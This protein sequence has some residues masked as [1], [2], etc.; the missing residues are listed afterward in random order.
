MVRFVIETDIGRGP[1]F[2]VFGVFS[3]LIPDGGLFSSRLVTVQVR[4]TPASAGSELEEVDS[5]AG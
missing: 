5:P 1:F 4:G 2:G 3:G